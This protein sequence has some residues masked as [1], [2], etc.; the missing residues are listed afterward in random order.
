LNQINHNLEIKVEARELGRNRS[1]LAPRI[2]TFVC[3]DDWS[4][5]LKAMKIWE[6]SQIDWW[7]IDS[8]KKDSEDLKYLQKRIENDQ[9]RQDFANKPRRRSR[10]V[11]FFSRFFSR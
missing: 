11:G 9:R 1:I 2:E 7:A 6:I 4:V 8:A 3:D 10:S 5:P